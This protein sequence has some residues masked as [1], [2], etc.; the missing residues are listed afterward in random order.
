MD[1]A[2]RRATAGLWSVQGIGP[3]TLEAIR[4]RVGPLAD[5]LERPPSAW[6]SFIDWQGEAFE[7]VTALPS[8][9]VAADRVERACKE[10]QAKI[11]FS[12]DPG[13]P[14]RLELIPEGPPMLFAFGPGA[15]APPRR[16]LAIVGTRTMAAG[17]GPRVEEIAQDA[18]LYGLGVISGAARGI[19]QAAHRG[20]L[21]VG[22]ETWAFLG[23]A[24]DEIDAPQ[25]E[26]CQQILDAGGT[27]FSEFP[28]GF[29]SN[30]HS[31]ILRN[32][33]ISGASDAVLVVRAP[34]KS[35]ALNTADHAQAQGRPLLVTAAEPWDVTA[36]GSNEL[37]REGKAQLHLDITDVLKAVGLTGSL[38]QAEVVASID[39]AELSEPAR[40]LL[41]HLGRGSDDFEGLQG[42]F[43]ALTS[44]QLSAALVE[45]EVFGAV[46]HKGGRRYEK[47]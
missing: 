37:L 6:A 40:L 4:R 46:L 44:G 27:L 25:R 28:P 24:L 14:S 3:V 31:F 39:P 20:A 22:A 10:M 43:P 12:G 11:L 21:K 32:R 7:R 19:D 45:L 17:F 15:D 8:L 9:A 5:L 30:L 34:A 26:I 13:F 18:G 29:R 23:S 41:A 35:G 2:E 16:R 38:S 1:T 33:L 47:R 42:V 36:L